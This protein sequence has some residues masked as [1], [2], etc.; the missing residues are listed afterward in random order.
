MVDGSSWY[1]PSLD[2]LVVSPCG[3]EGEPVCDSSRSGVSTTPVVPLASPYPSRVGRG[4]WNAMPIVK[5]ITP[6]SCSSPVSYKSQR[7]LNETLKNIKNNESSGVS[8]M[9]TLTALTATRLACKQLRTILVRFP[10]FNNTVL[11]DSEDMKSVHDGY[12]KRIHLYPGD[13]HTLGRPSHGFEHR[14]RRSSS[15]QRF[16]VRFAGRGARGRG[17]QRGAARLPLPGRKRRALIWP[18]ISL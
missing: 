1:S 10:Y 13:R 7:L 12:Y 9:C 8:Q 6:F 2:E 3:L 11:F 15:E 16:L 4:K 14:P 18:V 17:A 5:S